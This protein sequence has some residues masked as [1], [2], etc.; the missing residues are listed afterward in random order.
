LSTSSLSRLIEDYLADCRARGLSPKTLTDAYGYPLQQVF[1]P[2]CERN[3][4]TE[5]GQLNRRML[6]RLTAE[7]L[8]KGGKRGR[9]SRYIVDTYVRNVNL[10]LGWCRREGE[11]DQLEEVAHLE[12]DKVI[13]RL[14]A[15]T[16]CAHQTRALVRLR[17]TQRWGSP[18]IPS[19][20]TSP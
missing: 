4:V 12:R 14:L 18:E 11:I 19:E 10:F 1:L 15:D 9:L 7:L 6:N 3:E 5:V 20:P 17:R 13:L 16:G 8:E 2:W